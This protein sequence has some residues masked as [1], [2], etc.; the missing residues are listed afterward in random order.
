MS[1]TAL[2]KDPRRAGISIRDS[3]NPIPSN[4]RMELPELRTIHVPVKDLSHTANL[5]RMD[6]RRV[7][8]IL[9]PAAAQKDTAI[10]LENRIILHRAV[11]DTVTLL[12]RKEEVTTL[13]DNLKDMDRR[14]KRILINPI[15]PT[16]RTTENNPSRRN[17][18]NQR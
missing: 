4:H 11:P 17:H 7:K 1:T 3:R 16:T 13:A 9:V 18:A 2:V 14:V 15:D 8:T 5:D 12:H 10:N 6:H